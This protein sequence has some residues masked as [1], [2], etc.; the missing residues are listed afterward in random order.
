MKALLI[1]LRNPPLFALTEI[2]VDRPQMAWGRTYEP[3]QIG[4]F[5]ERLGFVD[6]LV[7]DPAG[8]VVGLSIF[9]LAD[10][11]SA[12]RHLPLEGLV[13][14]D[15]GQ[16]TVWFVDPPVPVD[17]ETSCTQ[18]YWCS[19]LYANSISGELLLALQWGEDNEHILRGPLSRRLTE[20]A[21]RT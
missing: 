2:D 17:W 19:Y 4:E 8:E 9:V 11:Q 7:P 14:N 10:D 6:W 3:A 13:T 5:P 1:A 12:L 15:R 16:L 20:F 21:R 18:E